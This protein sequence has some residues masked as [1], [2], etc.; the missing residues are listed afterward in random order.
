MSEGERNKTLWKG[1]QRPTHASKI[2]QSVL[3]VRIYLIPSVKE[4]HRRV[5]SR[6]LI[7]L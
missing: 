4:I 5:L 7:M 1:R 3:E 2:I 6:R